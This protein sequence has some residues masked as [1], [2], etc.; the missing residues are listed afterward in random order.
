[1]ETSKGT[2]QRSKL[3]ICRATGR[4]E[5]VNTHPPKSP[6]HV[7]EWQNP[8]K[9]LSSSK[10]LW[11]AWSV[12]SRE[13]CLKSTL[14]MKLIKYPTYGHKCDAYHLFAGCHTSTRF[15]L[16]CPHWEQHPKRLSILCQLKRSVVAQEDLLTIYVTDIRPVVVEYA[17]QVWHTNL[18]AYLSDKLEMI[19]KRALRSNFPGMHYKDILEQAMLPSLSVRREQ[20]DAEVILIR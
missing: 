12:E 11:P 5:S 19:Q 20:L 7:G 18:T 15:I 8:Q 16:E 3:G 9:S 17:C 14:F 6:L 10:G 2:K 1:M 4:V 13:K